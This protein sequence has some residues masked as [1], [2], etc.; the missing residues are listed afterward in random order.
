MVSG[1]KFNPISISVYQNKE[2]SNIPI[3]PLVI[4]NLTKNIKTGIFTQYNKS[5]K[6]LLLSIVLLKGIQE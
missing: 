4:E 1:S 6:N 2:I 5:L 3:F